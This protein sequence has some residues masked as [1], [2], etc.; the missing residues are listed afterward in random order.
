MEDERA[1]NPAPN[2]GPELATP[3]LPETPV[4]DDLAEGEEQEPIEEEEELDIDGLPL[5]VPKTIAEKLQARMMMQADYTKK[6]QDVAEQKRE[7]EA[8]RTEFQREAETNQQLFREKAEMY[9][10]ESRLHQLSQYNPVQLSPEDQQR[11]MLET[12][13][14]RQAR[15]DLGGRINHRQNEL[16]QNRERTNANAIR[17]AID[18]LNKPD[19]RFGWSGKFDSQVKAGLTQ[20]GK[21]L[22]FTDEEL[23]NTTHPRMIQTL[24][25]AKLGAE[26]LKKQRTAPQRPEA[27]PAAKVPTSRATGTR[28]PAKM[29]MEEYSAARKAGRIK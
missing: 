5:K 28:D 14:L 6:T 17:K 23:F 1:N 3:D 19:E 9:Q 24:H 22:G 8:Q 15:E 18:V 25:L 21:D 2:E 12:M 29:S 16:A 10:I 26:Y 11:F 4:P 13:Q 20:F 27:Q 7:F